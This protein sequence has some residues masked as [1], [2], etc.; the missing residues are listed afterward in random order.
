[1]F[2]L[3][4][5]LL[6]CVWSMQINAQSLEF[7]SA[8]TSDSK[9]ELPRYVVVEAKYNS[10]V[11]LT[12]G[13]D[14]LQET[15]ESNPY[16]NVEFRVGWRG[17]GRKRW[18]QL[19]NYMTYGVGI[20]HVFFVPYDNILGSPTAVYVYMDYPLVRLKNV[21]FGFD[22]A[23]G[24]A[25]G[26]K[27][28]DPIKN[29]DQKGIGSSFNVF[30]Q[31]NLNLGFK[32]SK[33]LDVAFQAG[34]SHYSN[35]RMR[36]PNKGINLMGGG[37][38]VVYN[39]KPFYKDGRDASHLPER[40]QYKRVE[41]PKHKKYIDINISGGLGVTGSFDDFET[42]DDTYYGAGGVSLEGMFKYSH[43]GRVGIGY[44]IFFDGSLVEEHDLPENKKIA[45]RD[46]LY[47]GIHISHEFLI[48][49]FGVIFQYGRTFQDVP[50]RGKS[51]VVAG[52][53]Y[54]VT[55]R[56]FLKVVLKTPTELIA[57]YGLVGAGFTLYSNRDKK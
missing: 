9:K 33:R 6:L 15:V 45:F 32:L 42:E 12:T 54:D 49:R 30:F 39:I 11:H 55:P 27:P 36:T 28:F 19:H 29:P 26:Y 47:G 10:G 20:N 53:R 34:L 56:T 3:I 13:V 17:Y 57:D 48:H 21:W 50:G 41:I 4:F 16:H 5:T 44:D 46:K 1:M 2:K 22:F 31:P 51:Y 37:L 40:P 38:K 43:V 7:L 23:V 8:D 14:K 52:C 24:G 25:V 35:G 18:Q